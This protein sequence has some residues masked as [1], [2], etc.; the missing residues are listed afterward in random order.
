[1]LDSNLMHYSINSLN[2]GSSIYLVFISKSGIK[3]KL[4][5]ENWPLIMICWL[6]TFEIVI[7]K[8]GYTDKMRIKSGK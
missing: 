3:M 4:K 8:L 5:I 1:M 6:F 2:I 7:L